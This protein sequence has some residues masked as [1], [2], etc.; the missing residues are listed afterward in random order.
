MTTQQAQ[1]ETAIE[2]LANAMDDLAFQSGI[3][4]RTYN[5]RATE[6]LAQFSKAVA[7]VAC[8]PLWNEPDFSDN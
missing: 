2:N 4:L 6:V 5:E 1:A 7:N 3:V 8:H